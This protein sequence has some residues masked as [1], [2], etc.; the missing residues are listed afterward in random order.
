MTARRTLLLLLALAI[1]SSTPFSASAQTATTTTAPATTQSTLLLKENDLLAICGDSITEQKLYSVYIEDYLLMCKPTQ[2]VHAMQFGWGGEKV[3]GFLHRM[4]NV[5]RF[6]VTVAT[7]LYG[8]NDGYYGP[9]TP[10]HAQAYRDGTKAIVETFKK[11]GVRVIVVGSPGVVDSKTFRP[12]NPDEDK[13]YNK[14]LSE[15]RDI[16]RDVAKA[17][18]VNFADVHATMAEAMLKAKAKYGEDY[19]IAGGDGVHPGPNGHIVMAYA[20][21]KAM[22]CDGDIGTITID[23]AG[24][25]ADATAGHKV[26]SAKDGA[27]EIES[28]RYPFCF[29]GDPK[30]PDATLGM[31][32]FFP[33]NQDLNRLKLIVNNVASERV[34]ITWG[35][36][37]KEY[38]AADLAKGINLAADFAA[39][40]PFQEQFKKVEEAIRAQ[41]NYETPLIKNL[42]H[43]WPGYVQLLPEQKDALDKIAQAAIDKAKGLNDASAAGVTPVKHTIK[44][45]KIAPPPPPPPPA[46]T[47]SPAATA[48]APAK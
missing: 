1:D 16:A 33:F 38:A 40:N 42:L 20:F 17:E 47:P 44:V 6:P 9:L 10:E 21:L 48:P 2:S 46:T 29:F 5:L 37:S 30:T 23:L 22:G 34:K 36:E 8:M 18:G 27:I 45:E 41:Q 13:V 24:N 43:N 39:K 31:I 4:S 15:L 14:T 25:K 12:N 26:L 11:S 7:T 28:T 35:G 3:D 19:P 32:E